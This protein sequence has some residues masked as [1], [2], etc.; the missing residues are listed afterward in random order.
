MGG[1]RIAVVDDDPRI[2]RLIRRSLEPE[3]YR[4]EEA[5]SAAE[6]FAMAS[7]SH[8]DLIALDINLPDEDGFEIAKRIRA[9]FDTPIIMVTGKGDVVDRVVGLEIGAD[10]YLPKPFQVRELL[11]RVKAVLRRTGNSAAPSGSEP[12]YWVD[13]LRVFPARRAVL[14]DANR[15]ITLTSGEYDLFLA[16][17]EAN[18]RA[19][20]RDQLMDVI[21]GRDAVPFD[22]SVDNL[23]LRLR[24][25]LPDGMVKTVRT[26]GYQL[27]A[28]ARPARL[29]WSPR[30]QD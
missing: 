6:L 20:T 22:R 21:H 14:D 15:E 3:G 8:F 29:V 28:P 30:S 23:V 11:A 26:V 18:G 13:T 7:E 27:A 4:V 9:T 2:R 1:P 17:V 16:L 19:M 25:R 5:G 10:D 24:K 12:G